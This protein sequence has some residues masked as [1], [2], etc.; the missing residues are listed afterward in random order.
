MVVMV[1]KDG[2]ITDL[3]VRDVSTL[4]LADLIAQ[5]RPPGEN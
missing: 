5:A 2:K 1:G 3:E 4:L